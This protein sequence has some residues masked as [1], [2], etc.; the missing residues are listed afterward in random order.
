[1]ATFQA[2]SKN[3]AE[4]TVVHGS[5]SYLKCDQ[6]LSARIGTKARLGSYSCM[7]SKAGHYRVCAEECCL[8]AVK[9]EDNGRRI[10]WLEA[11]ARWVSLGRQETASDSVPVAKRQHSTPPTNNGGS[12]PVEELLAESPF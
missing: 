12:S 2:S 11:A 8:N 3:S 4:V 5:S 1:M 9:V 6:C 10:H 7:S